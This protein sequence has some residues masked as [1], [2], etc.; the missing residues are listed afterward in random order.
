MPA[1]GWEFLVSQARLGARAA[2][3]RWLLPFR[4]LGRARPAARHLPV[5]VAPE[6]QAV[7]DDV[8]YGFGRTDE[9]GRVADRAMPARW[10]GS[11]ETG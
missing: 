11:L 4:N 10:A 7:P 6:V 3:R 5:A 1:A 8:L 2:G 9:S